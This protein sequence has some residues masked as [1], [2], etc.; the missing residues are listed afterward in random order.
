[1]QKF[2]FFVKIVLWKGLNRYDSIFIPIFIS[3][4]TIKWFIVFDAIG[5]V[6]AIFGLFLA[7]K[8]KFKLSIYLNISVLMCLILSIV[9]VMVIIFNH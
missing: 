9:L 4:S 8:N 1:M 3:I 7:I 6:M 5:I 2:C